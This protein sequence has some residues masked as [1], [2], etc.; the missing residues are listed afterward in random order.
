MVSILTL[1]PRPAGNVSIHARLVLIKQLAYPVK[2]AFS[3]I[4]EPLLVL[5]DVLKDFMLIKQLYHVKLVIQN[6]LNVLV[7][8]IN[9]A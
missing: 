1:H 8:L 4:K 2:M 7:H 9:N 5:R 6:V 3:L